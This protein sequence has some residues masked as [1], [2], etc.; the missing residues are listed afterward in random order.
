[1]SLLKD[2]ST[3][4]LKSIVHVIQHVNFQLYRAHHE[5]VTWKKL[6]TDDKYINKRVCLFI[7]Q[8]MSLRRVE[9][10]NYSD[11]IEVHTPAK[12]LFNYF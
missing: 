9:K 5:G 4:T 1:M 6:I 7:N 3:S 10:K 12:W 11:V 8:T 2:T